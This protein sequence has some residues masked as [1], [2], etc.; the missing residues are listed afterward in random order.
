MQLFDDCVRTDDS[1]NT[2]VGRLYP[3]LNR[4]SWPVCDRARTLCEDWFSRYP[5]DGS[6]DLH[7]RFTSRR[8]EDHR[9]AYFELL[10]HEVLTRLGGKVTVHPSVP[11]TTKKPDF[12]VELEGARF[13]LEAMVNHAKEYNFRNS[14]ILD[15]VCDWINELDIPDYFVHIIFSGVPSNTPTKKSISAQVSRLI[16]LSNSEIT[17]Q[18][19]LEDGHPAL[20]QGF[21]KIADALARVS[22]I[23]RAVEHKD[24]AE[25]R[26]VIRSAGGE[27][28]DVA[29]KWCES[30][31]RKAN[32]KELDRYDAPSVIAID[33]M[34]GFA[35]IGGKGVQ[36]VYGM[37]DNPQRQ[38]GLWKRLNNNSWQDNLAAVWMFNYV[39]PV[40]ASP[41]GI[42]DCLLLR[43]SIEQPL[44]KSL[45]QLNQI[46]PEKGEL[47]W[48]DGVS[49]DELLEV[50]EIP[51]EE[52]RRVPPKSASH[53]TTDPPTPPPADPPPTPTATCGFL[54]G[55]R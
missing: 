4:S 42:E 26:N 52:L 21:M 23:P 34:D 48:R 14:P 41:C 45:E 11:G 27:M 7:R 1:P 55:R 12:L 2:L 43:P 39:E 33:V 15:T 9:S 47:Q 44:P 31:R 5:T 22:L 46:K 53:P 10:L 30:I 19:L 20:T 8:D 50:P 6:K 17:R 13:Y 18:Q 40:Q 51:Y 49:L 28:H 3:F 32:A 24:V 54:G 16:Q 35:R 25:L 38:S 37:G 36:A 29:P